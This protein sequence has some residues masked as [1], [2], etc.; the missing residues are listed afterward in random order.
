MEYLVHIGIIVCIWAIASLSLN[1]LV[2]E[3]GLV[4]VTH[5]AF[6][7]IG[8]YVCALLLLSTGMSFFLAAGIAM[9][10]AGFIAFILGIIFLRL[11]E[12]YFVFGTLGFNIIAWSVLLNWDSVTRGPLGIPGIPRPELFGFVFTSN[13]A[14]FLLALAGLIATYV[15]CRYI[16]NSSFGRVLHAIREDE[17]AT[18]LFGYKTTHYKIAI[19]TIAAMPAA[20]SSALFATYIGYINPASF[21]LSESVFVLATVIVGGLGS[22][23]GAILGAFLLSVLPEL[24]RFVGFPSEVAGELRQL[25]YGLLLIVLMQFR[26]RGFLGNFRI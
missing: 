3:T 11:R 4:S 13:Q 8:A 17:D 5:I 9:L 25:S 15:L 14:F 26:P 24:L 12:V 1:L 2:G 21:T 6:C 16:Q 7:G 22:S 10:V 19:F 23:S 20:Y 18:A